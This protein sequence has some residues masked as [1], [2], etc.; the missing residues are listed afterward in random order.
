[1]KIIL[2]VYIFALYIIFTSGILIN[3][4]FE[5]LCSILFSVIL[6]FTLDII[7][8]KTIESLQEKNGDNSINVRFHNIVSDSPETSTVV[9]EYLVNAYSDLY[10]IQDKE[11]EL[12]KQLNSYTGTDKEFNLLQNLYDRTEVTSKRFKKRFDT[13]T[14]ME[15]QITDLKKTVSKSEVNERNYE[16]KYNK[17]NVDY[18]NS[19]GTLLTTNMQIQNMTRSMLDVNKNTDILKGS[20][21]KMNGKIP[22]YETYNANMKNICKLMSNPLI[23][24]DKPIAIKA[25]EIFSTTY[26]LKA[27]IYVI[28][29]EVGSDWWHQR[30]TSI[31]VTTD[32]ILLG[33]L[34]ITDY[35][36]DIC[37]IKGNQKCKYPTNAISRI[38]IP[39][40]NTKILVHNITVTASGV[41]SK[42]SQFF[43]N[44]VKVYY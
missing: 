36:D 5:L 20:M 25:P 22:Q 19:D 9:A 38:V 44:Y 2:L 29:V 8:K 28:K 14:N 17:C 15:E 32:D 37:G 43:I 12:K 3:K 7:N 33:E 39:I 16:K 21:I 11:K 30:P 10:K 41:F 13:Y 40:N 23:I 24:Y 1:M 18:E 42:E 4:D 35:Q 26:E 27:P 31:K 6:F 34:N